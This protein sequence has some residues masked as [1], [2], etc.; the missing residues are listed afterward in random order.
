VRSWLPSLPP[1]RDDDPGKTPPPLKQRR[2]KGGPARKRG[3]Q[4]AAPGSYLAW[5]KNPGVRRDRLPAGCCECGRDLQAATD[6]GVVDR[7]EQHDIPPVSVTVTQYDAHQVA[8][9]CGRFHTAGRLEGSRGGQVGYGPNLQAFAVY[10]MVMHF[11][12]VG[13]LRGIAGIADQGGPQCRV[14]ARP[15]SPAPQHYWRRRTSGSPR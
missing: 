11:V 15:C 13:R 14:R 1:S 2:S 7:Y 8:C 10:L 3:K 4:P 5:T 12:P 6:L 9:G